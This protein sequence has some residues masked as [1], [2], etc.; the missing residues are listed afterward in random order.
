MT[1]IFIRKLETFSPLSDDDK[2]FIASVDP[3]LRLCICRDRHHTRRRRADGRPVD[4]DRPCLPV[5]ASSPGP[6]PDRR[7][8][9][10]GRHLR[11]SRRSSR[12]D[13]P[14]HRGAFAASRVVRISRSDISALL[15]RPAIARALLMVTLVNE[16]IGRDWLANVGG[17][18]GR[19]EAGAPSLRMAPAAATGGIDEGGRMRVPAHPD[20]CLGTR[21]G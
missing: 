20:P 14:Q 16:S 19:A 1:D 21:S 2:R 10:S 6:A 15:E 8:P 4:R 12:C 7:F 3:A 17:T 9:V 18:P 11:P 5:Q 13:G